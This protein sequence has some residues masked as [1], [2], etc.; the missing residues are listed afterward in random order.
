VSLGV[1]VQRRTTEVLSG[2]I[3]LKRTDEYYNVVPVLLRVQS[4]SVLTGFYREYVRRLQMP[5]FSKAENWEKC[6]ALYYFTVR[7]Q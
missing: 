5:E 3:E 1:Y 2:E 7:P 4:Y 6:F